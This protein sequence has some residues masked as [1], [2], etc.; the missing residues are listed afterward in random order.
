M[1]DKNRIDK[2]TGLQPR[3]AEYPKALLKKKP[4]SRY[5]MRQSQNVSKLRPARNKGR[6]RV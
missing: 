5:N 2:A 6:S 3:K 4:Y 1:E